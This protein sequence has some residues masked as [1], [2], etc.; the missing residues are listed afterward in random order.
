M[1]CASLE[2]ISNL[3]IS[4]RLSLIDL[5]RQWHPPSPM[6]GARTV[7]SARPKSPPLRCT[8]PA[9]TA[10]LLPIVALPYPHP[11][12]LTY[13]PHLPTPTPPTQQRSRPD[14]SPQPQ[15]RTSP[16]SPASYQNSCS[17]ATINPTI[18]AVIRVNTN[19][20]YYAATRTTLAVLFIN[21]RATRRHATQ[22][23]RTP[24]PPRLARPHPPGRMNA[25][26]IRN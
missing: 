25:T 26:P 21:N 23:G 24:R 22:P 20:P 14:Y 15:G 3:T 4:V 13:C 10:S 9:L 17:Q 8:W 5:P 2:W 18:H 16:P 1:A 6:P 11:A 19:H 7:Y 12:H